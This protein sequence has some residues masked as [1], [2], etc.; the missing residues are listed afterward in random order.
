[1][2][3]LLI[4]LP[5]SS[6]KVALAEEDMIPITGDYNDYDDYI[7]LDFDDLN[8]SDKINN[9]L[10]DENNAFATLLA[11]IFG[12]FFLLFFITA[13]LVSYIYYSL[14][15][16]KIADKLGEKNSWYA[17]IPIFNII[18]FFRMGDQNPWLILIAL[19]PGI[20]G[21]VLAVLSI[22][23]MCNICEKRGYDKLLGLLSLIPI[24][25][26]VLMGILA[27]GKDKVTTPESK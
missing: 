14:A 24:A 25:N 23:A 15:L 27:W 9:S 4:A 26:F 2:L 1:M 6:K 11:T 16:Q 7:D 12:G 17:W 19:I 3:F 20:G 10:T 5:L 22:I 8:F 18:L 21:I 13:T